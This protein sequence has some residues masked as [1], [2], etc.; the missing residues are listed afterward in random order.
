MALLSLVLYSVSQ[1]SLA[2][3][4]NP[5]P[6]ASQTEE[7]NTQAVAEAYLQ[8]QEQLRATQVAIEQNHEE[9]R[10]AAAQS[11]E[12]FSKALQT[13]QEG[14]AAQRARDLEAMQ[15]SNKFILFMVSI[16]AAMGFLS[17][18]VISYSQWRMSKGLAEISAAL[19]VVL[20]LG[21]G[22][23][24]AA[25][26]PGQPSKL[27][28]L[29]ATE[30]AEMRNQEPDQ[31][32]PRLAVKP[33]DGHNRPGENRFFPG[34]GNWLQRRQI[35]PLRI[36]VIVGLICAAALALLFYI[37]TWRKL[38]FGYFHGVSKS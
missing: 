26:G 17:M 23:T 11:A 31:Q 36:A 12:A 24:V 32:P 35:R 21:A 2:A 1:A 20:G 27:R 5:P 37:V 33:R 14:F 9:I 30:R 3:E 29:G 38:G 10:A 25:L 8:L 28:Q 19:P 22:S 4:T 34:T 18:L 15:Q 6:T 16:F 7:T 13:L